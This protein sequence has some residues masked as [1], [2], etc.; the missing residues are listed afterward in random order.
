MSAAR[1]SGWLGPV[2]AALA[3]DGPRVRVF[4]RDDDAGWDDARLVSLCDVFARREQP[5]D[6]AVIPAALDER[7]ARWLRARAAS[8]P[9]ELHQH[10]YA[11]RSHER[12][13]RKQEFGPARGPREQ[14][15][16]IARGR[17]LL[18]ERL[19]GLTRPIFTP[20]WNRCT[21]DTGRVLAQL[22]F[23]VLS[24][25][26][27]ALALGVPRLVECPVHVDWLARERSGERRSA[28]DLGRRL[29]DA[30]AAGG[31][32]G[33]MLHHAVMDAGD[34]A[35]VAELLD[36]LAGSER[37]HACQ[38]WEAARQPPADPPVRM[39]LGRKSTGA[40]DAAR[41]KLS[42]APSWRPRS[43][44]RKGRA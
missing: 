32:C 22:G 17:A 37:V 4:F 31:P 18:A 3:A 14:A 21:A 41:S 44:L 11:H 19:G 2:R 12:E 23:E 16:D 43:G 38:L 5:L 33:V 40:G 7:L 39:V 26:S 27:R 15:A 29:G 42:T 36:V 10:G 30:L 24:R 28:S 20:P 35:A 6:L 1:D 34:R 9:L 13:G 25:E 8:S